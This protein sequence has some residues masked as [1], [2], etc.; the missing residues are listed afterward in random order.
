[1]KE[2]ATKLKFRTHLACSGVSLALF[3]LARCL[4]HGIAVAEG[5]FQGLTPELLYSRAIYFDKDMGAELHK[6]VTHGKI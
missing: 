5:D 4:S 2:E 6:L 1:M 3:L